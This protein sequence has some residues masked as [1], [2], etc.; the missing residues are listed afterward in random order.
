MGDRRLN[1]ERAITAIAGIPV[2][3]SARSSI[4]ET[5]PQDI[6]NQPWFLNIVLECRTTMFPLQ[7]L[8]RLRA[9]ERDLGRTR[10]KDVTPKGPRVIDI[11]ILLYGK[12]II[13]TAPLTVPHERMLERRFVLEPL[14]QINPDLRDPRSG[15]LLSEQL[16]ALNGQ[17]VRRIDE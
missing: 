6:A 7:L 1:L 8:S 5:E 3:V 17:I 4:Y 2:T 10:G 16:Q 9:I 14:V 13:R 12:S 11:D 15:R